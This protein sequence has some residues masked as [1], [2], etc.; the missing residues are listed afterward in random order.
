[1]SIIRFTA[2]VAAVGV[3]G[4]S[5][6]S[7]Y[8]QDFQGAVGSEWSSSSVTSAPSNSNRKFLGE[9]GAETVTLSLSGLTA[10][11]TYSLAFDFLALKSWD[12]S[13]GFYGPDYFTVAADSTTLLNET[14]SNAGWNQSYSAAGSGDFAFQTNADEVNTL[15]YSFFGDSV[16]K[17]GGAINSGFTFVAGGSTASITFTGG[18]NQGLG[19]E[20]WGID[21]VNVEAVPEP[22]TMAVL[23]LGAL[24]LRRRKS[25]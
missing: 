12:G 9:F 21:N 10:G 7:V 4:S 6:A 16:Y 5:F 2:F 23:A 14:F 11:S 20:S 8:T 22:M 24:A 1:M 3:A 17:F 25:A 13:N 18:A 19:D 15:G